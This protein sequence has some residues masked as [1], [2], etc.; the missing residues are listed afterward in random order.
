MRDALGPDIE[1]GRLARGGFRLQHVELFNWGTFDQRVWRL[2]PRGHNILLT[3]DIG[4]GK[5]T[6]VDALTTLLVAPHKLAYNKAAGADE[7][8]RSLR[9]YVLGHYKSERADSGDGARAV[10]LRDCNDYSVLLAVFH[11]QPLGESV[12]LAQ[13]FWMKD[14]REQPER[15]YVVAEGRLA[16]SEHFAGFGADIAQLRKR[17]RATAGVSVYDTFLPYGAEF[18]RRF[19]IPSEQAMDLLHQTVSMKSVGNLSE[20]VREHMLE[21]FPVEPRIAGL[22]A[23]FDGLNRAH[24]AVLKA[25]AQIDQ[26]T[27]LVAECDRYAEQSRRVDLWRACREALRPWCAQL[28]RA[29]LE[30]RACELQAELDAVADRLA[31]LAESRRNQR[32]RRDALVEASATNGGN[33][34]GQIGAEIS[35]LERTRDERAARAQQYGRVAAELGLTGAAGAATFAANRRAIEDGLVTCAQRRDEAGTRLTEAGVA[36]RELGRQYSE[37]TAE[38]QSL[39]ARSSNIPR[40]LIEMRTGLCDAVRAAPGELPFA[41]ELIQVADGAVWEGVAERLLRPFAQ[42]LLVP[43]IHY[44]AVASWAARA[45][46]GVQL[47]FYRVR[48]GATPSQSNLHP[49]SLVRQLLVKPGSP[50]YSWMQAELQQHFDYACCDDNQQFHRE[51]RAVHRDGRIKSNGDRHDKDDR[52]PIGERANYVLGWTNEAKIGALSK[53]ERDL[54]TRIQAHVAQVSAC[55]RDLDEHARLLG[56]WQQL[57]LYSGFKELDWKAPAAMIEQL[58]RE[59]QELSTSTDTVSELARQIDALA[60]AQEAAEAELEEAIRTHARLAE[61]LSQTTQALAGCAAG[62]D[63]VPADAAVELDQIKG[64]LLGER[65]LSAQACDRFEI[66]MH[67]LLQAKAEV[68]EQRSL[69]LRDAIIGAM[70]EYAR[71]WPV[72][73]REVDVSVGAAE[74]YRHMLLALRTQELSALLVRFQQ[75]LNE[76][77]VRGITG[78]HSQLQREYALVRERVSAIN[79]SLQDIDYNPGRY[80]RLETQ[81]N[82]DVELRDFQYD[83]RSCIEQEPGTNEAGLEARFLQ[84]KRLVQRFRG[85]EGSAEADQRWTRKVTDVRNWLVFSASERWREDDGEH[86]HYT[87]AAGKSGGQKE[88]LAYT[89][90]AAGLACQFGRDGERDSPRSFRFAMIDEA[91]GRGSD[92]SARYGLELFERMGL[93]LLVVTPLQKIH[94]IEPYVAGLGFVHSEAGQRSMLRYLDIGEYRAELNARVSAGEVA[95]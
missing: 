76:E 22:V 58:E 67:E 91:F 10:S 28:K 7:R 17:L 27:P 77:I 88:K 18:R 4:S 13:V 59:R 19:G 6:L 30:Q 70:Q 49:D 42:S 57:A 41:G 71:A 8:E 82:L 51:K 89:V 95:D 55:R 23:D 64:Q 24:E 1:V 83:L 48:A 38:L 47:S 85:R 75:L 46:P 68:E 93:Q 74:E 36:V 12:T 94:V 5:S 87:D 43:D 25:R 81:A 61:Q 53:Q 2:A 45:H 33:R 72:D 52:H 35:R 86:E 11:N 40:R 31:A 62:D 21:G 63:P 3:G 73:T 60:V 15:L 92:D 26:L 79:A 50:Y 90:L 20:F 84:I 78:L 69:P 80:I 66:D 44:R 56:F 39:R 37:L 9:S 29:M 54:A 32:L 16:I 14:P 65:A 34:I